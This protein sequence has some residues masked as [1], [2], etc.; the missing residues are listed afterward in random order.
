MHPQSPAPDGSFRASEFDGIVA[1][2]DG[3]SRGNPGPAGF[4]VYIQDSTGKVLA[5]LSQYLGART[6]NFAEYSALL[7]ALEFAITHGHKSLRVISDSELMV[8]QMKG[9]YRVNSPEL[10]PLYEEARRRISQLNHFQ[11]QHVLREKNRH[12]D[13]LANLAMDRGMGRAP[14]ATPAP[15][16][17]ALAKPVMLRG[18]VKGGVVHV[19]G[20]E[21]PDGTFVK[22]IPE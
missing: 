7:A 3:G 22:L 21:L 4:G 8:K 14:A 10:R 12:A 18:L 9:Q 19:L 5:E 2:C 11:I 1:Y 6:N 16:P 17:S 20:G 15:A 13:R